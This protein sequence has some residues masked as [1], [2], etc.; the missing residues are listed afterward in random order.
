MPLLS[1]FSQ[2]R[3]DVDAACRREDLFENLRELM[4]A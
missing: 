1:S 2:R 4:E 3:W